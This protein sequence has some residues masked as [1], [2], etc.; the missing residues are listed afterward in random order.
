MRTYHLKDDGTPVECPAQIKC[1]KENG[2]APHHIGDLSSARKW[3]EEKNS[4]RTGQAEVPVARSRF[5]RFAAPSEEDLKRI[6][7]QK[8]ER[9]RAVAQQEVERQARRTKAK[10]LPK[11]KSSVAKNG[12]QGFSGYNARTVSTVDS[13]LEPIDSM[14]PSSSG[15]FEDY[16]QAKYRA[17]APLTKNITHYGKT[18]GLNDDDMVTI[19][20]GVPDGVDSVNN[21]DFVTTNRQL[22]EGYGKRVLEMK[23]PAKHVL[24]DT[25]EPLGD[26]YIYRISD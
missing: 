17:T 22:A 1:R 25:D 23:V 6:Q 20:R 8:A 5:S 14:N 21:G 15:V 7:E 13:T 18:A 3:A 2:D 10:S 4:K 12:A 26:E 24:D 9:E 19:Y 16:D 11:I